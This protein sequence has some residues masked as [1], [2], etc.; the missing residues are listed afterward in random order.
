[1]DE[2]RILGVWRLDSHATFEIEKY[3]ILEM[4]KLLS[5]LI[6]VFQAL[7]WFQLS[8]VACVTHAK[9]T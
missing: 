9:I 7:T 2:S 8:G 1:M 6:V 3:A 4:N 5:V